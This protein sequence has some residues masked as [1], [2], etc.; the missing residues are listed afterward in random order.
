[1]IPLVSLGIV[2]T[3]SHYSRH[4]FTYLPEPAC[5]IH[6]AIY[7]F[8][9]FLLIAYKRAYTLQWVSEPVP[10]FEDGAV[11]TGWS[12]CLTLGLAPVKLDRD[13]QS[14]WGGM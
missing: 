14:K 8:S 3:V 5:V 9:L 11:A 1:M 7:G 4:Q 2:M 12:P 10:L 6:T 13:V